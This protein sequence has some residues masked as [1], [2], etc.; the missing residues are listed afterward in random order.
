LKYD[1]TPPATGIAPDIADFLRETGAEEVFIAASTMPP[2]TVGDVDEDDAVIEAFREVSAVRP[3]LL[4]ILAPRKP[5]RFDIVAEKLS[6]AGV[7]FTRRT[8]LKPLSL[9]GVRCSTPSEN[10]QPF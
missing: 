10:W 7:A 2:A 5:E 8:S 9:P 6:H 1:F 3:A 4:L